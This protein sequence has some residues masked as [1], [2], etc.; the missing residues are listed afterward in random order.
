MM[1]THMPL[2]RANLCMAMLRQKLLLIAPWVLEICCQKKKKK[3]T[4]I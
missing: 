4:Q 3:W 1:S 2:T